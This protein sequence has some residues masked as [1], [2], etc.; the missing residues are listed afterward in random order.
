ML[1]LKNEAEYIEIGLSSLYT[2]AK[3]GMGL[4]LT[5]D[6][7]IMLSKEVGF[8]NSKYIKEEQDLFEQELKKIM[9][10]KYGIEEIQIANF[11]IINC[12]E[13]KN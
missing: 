10:Q 13:N 9:I 11:P 12:Q 1:Y 8:S 6:D 3:F 2:M 7:L 4:N 5:A